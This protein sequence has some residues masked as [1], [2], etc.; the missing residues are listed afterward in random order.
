MKILAI[1]GEKLASLERFE[2]RFDRGPLAQSGLFVICGPTGAG[3]STLLDAM[4]LALYDRTP[5]LGTGKGPL[6]LL[7]RGAVH[8]AAAVEFRDQH[9]KRYRASWQIHR[10][11]RRPTG[12]WQEPQVELISL[13]SGESLGSH[14]KRDT[15]ELIERKVGLGFE[16]F[17]RSVLLAQGEFSRFLR[18]TGDDRARLLETITGG[19][20]YTELSRQAFLS[21]KSAGEA[22]ERTQARLQSL[23]QLTGDQRAELRR[24]ETTL[25]DKKQ[26]LERGE[27]AA[28]ERLAWDKEHAQR[29][30]EV[31]Q[32]Q[33]RQQAAHTALL[34]A[35]PLRSELVLLERAET[36]RPALLERARS[37]TALQKV[38]KLMAAGSAPLLEAAIRE[39]DE[40]AQARL[41]RQREREALERELEVFE[42]DLRLA[43][44]SADLI[45]RRA[46]LLKPNKPCPLCGSLKHP[47]AQGQLFEASDEKSL[48][49]RLKQQRDV[50]FS[51]EQQAQSRER[52]AF[53]AEQTAAARRAAVQAAAEKARELA[54]VQRDAARADREAAEVAY[55]SALAA[56]QLTESDEPSVL[57]L[58]DVPRTTRDAQRQQV[59]ALERAIVESDSQ[60]ADR[61]RRLDELDPESPQ[62]QTAHRA[63]QAAIETAATLLDE[64]SARELR[65]S[66]SRCGAT[67]HAARKQAEEQL[68]HL[69]LKLHQDEAA[70]R[71]AE[72]LQ[73]E[74]VAQRRTLADWA[75]LAELIGSADGKKFRVFAQGLTL[76]TLLA[77]ANQHLLRLRPRYALR[78]KN[79]RMELEMI[80]RDMGDEARD[81]ATLS[82]GETFLV[83]LALALGLSSL[84]ARSVRVESLFIDEGFGSLDR[85]ALDGALS[86]LEELEASGQQIGVISHVL[87]L[88][89]RVAYRVLVEPHRPGRSTVTILGPGT[90]P[91]TTPEMQSSRL[92]ADSQEGTFAHVDL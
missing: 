23:V 65:L 53:V 41:E 48:L 59:A 26:S 21:C 73:A 25:V 4:C 87:E 82:G 70:R 78:R 79:E 22:L 91:G 60:L 9:G 33:A 90:T 63:W 67:L 86:V 42:A 31:S 5:R 29:S 80:D 66:P 2:V 28:M 34:Q 50:L 51:Q 32:A 69:A 76:D 15:L 56:A 64:N 83:S 47:A 16:Q 39:H 89:E 62:H 52:E 84:A 46:E 92:L 43:H 68:L 81:C 88:A 49:V 58:L 13:D 38:D 45:A 8:A 3:K 17:C 11:R 57:Q 6:G 30:L 7:Q 72:T 14:R 40:R 71:E 12:D 19:E 36:I 44:A 37:E 18:E 54:E 85:D 1:S 27:Q 55:R 61:R 10:A 74:L 35:A 75:V 24:E 77:H 20:I